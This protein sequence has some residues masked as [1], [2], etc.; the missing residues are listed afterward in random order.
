MRPVLM[1]TLTTVFAQTFMAL[2]TSMDAALLRPMALVTVGGLTYG[3]IMTLIFVP[4]IYDIFTSDK[5]M[6][7]LEIDDTLIAEA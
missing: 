3:T 4:C 1:T 6:K 5:P 2:G 7:D